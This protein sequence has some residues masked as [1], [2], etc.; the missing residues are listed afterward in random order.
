MVCMVVKIE[1]DLILPPR[2]SVLQEKSQSKLKL[3]STKDWETLEVL[4][5]QGTNCPR[6]A[7][8]AISSKLYVFWLVSFIDQTLIQFAGYWVEHQPSDSS[9]FQCCLIR[10]RS[11]TKVTA[12][13]FQILIILAASKWSIYLC[14]LETVIPVSPGTGVHD[15]AFL[16]YFWYIPLLPLVLFFSGVDLFHD[17]RL[18]LYHS[19]YWPEIAAVYNNNEICCFCWTVILFLSKKW[20]KASYRK[21]HTY[22]HWLIHLFCF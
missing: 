16:L 6:H 8:L 3:P 14:I 17:I 2:S 11:F 13:T 20:V 12:Y 4:K 18:H 10:L 1:L 7:Q 15:F 19:T 22:T 21:T 5:D 9:S